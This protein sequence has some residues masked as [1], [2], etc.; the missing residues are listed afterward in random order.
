[1]LAQDVTNRLQAG[2]AHG[3]TVAIIDRF[4]VIEIEEHQPKR[5]AGFPCRV[6]TRCK[7]C[8]EFRPV[9]QSGQ[10]VGAGLMA[11]DVQL[12][13]RITGCARRGQHQHQRADRVG[14]RMQPLQHGRRALM[15]EEKPYPCHASDGHA[16]PTNQV[17]PTLRRTG[18]RARGG[19]TQR[20]HRQC[21]GHDIDCL[22]GQR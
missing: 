3:M 16:T 13:F 1:M 10:E 19:R 2:V 6:Q 11:G 21:Q 7:G 4:E 8:I 5:C 20:K 14:Q 9:G 12:A 15:V 17:E 22:V 18:A